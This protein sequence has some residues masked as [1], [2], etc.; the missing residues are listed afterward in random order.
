[1]IHSI[2]PDCSPLLLVMD[3]L[4]C[5]ARLP[6]IVARLRRT[7]CTSVA[8]SSNHKQAEPAGG[9]RSRHSDRPQ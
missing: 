7:D 8:H 2:V 3:C 4:L 5:S 6:Q 9:I 1:M